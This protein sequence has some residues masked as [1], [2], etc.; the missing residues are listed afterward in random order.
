MQGLPPGGTNHMPDLPPG[1]TNHM[2][3]LPP[4]GKAQCNPEINKA[5][6]AL[7]RAI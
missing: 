1:G 2:Q 4:G 5:T 6:R 7:K 3:V